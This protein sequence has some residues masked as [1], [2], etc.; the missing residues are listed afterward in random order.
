MRPSQT[1][2]RHPARTP[3]DCG[4][5]GFGEGVVEATILAEGRRCSRRA[6][7]RPLGG[8]PEQGRGLRC[9]RIY[10]ETRTSLPERAESALP[11]QNRPISGACAVLGPPRGARRD[12][13]VRF[14]LIRAV[15]TQ[16]AT[17]SCIDP[18]SWTEPCWRL[19]GWPRA[20]ERERCS[21]RI[22]TSL[23]RR[24]P[25]R[26]RCPVVLSQSYRGHPAAATV[27]G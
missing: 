18:A 2:P 3:A 6:P 24:G 22:G 9:A 13:G 14:R 4:A 21:G 27:R 17:Q 10:R 20:L 8:R 26:P 15:A 25:R 12:P 7:P 5:C 11:V 1:R 23:P 19:R 16:R